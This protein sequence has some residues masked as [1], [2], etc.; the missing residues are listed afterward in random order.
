M[1]TLKELYD[2]VKSLHWTGGYI[3]PEYIDENKQYLPYKLEFY[4][5]LA[6]IVLY[7][8]DEFEIEKIID[9]CIE[10]QCNK[11]GIYKIIYI[12]GAALGTFENEALWPI[13][14]QIIEFWRKGEMFVNES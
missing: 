2:L 4:K 10:L 9:N 13:Q 5:D 6:F 8:E 14:Y 1:R 3:A 11:N 7:R 12:D